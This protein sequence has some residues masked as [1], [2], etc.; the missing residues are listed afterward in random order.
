MLRNKKIVVIL[1]PTA[2]GK[3]KLSIELAKLFNGEIVSADSR[4][5]YKKMDIGTDKISKKERKG[6]PHYL[7]DVASPKKTFTVARYKDLAVKA[8]KKIQKN[9]KI[10]FLVGGTG[11]YIQAV[12]D[13]LLVPEVK[14]DW[15]LRKEL[16]KKSAEELFDILKE[17]DPQRAKSIDR[18][19]KRRLI[20]AIEII[21]KTKKPVS[22]LKKIKPDFEVLKIGIKKSQKSLKKAIKERF[23]RWL[24]QGLIKEVK[25][26]R[27]AGLSWKKIEEFGIHYRQIALYLQNKI[28]REEMIEKSLK[29]L[30]QYAK[31]Q[32]T[33]FKKDKEIH[34][35]KNKGEA[36]KAVKKFLEKN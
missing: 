20:R 32:M 21:T 35:I 22:P 30:E 8:I 6:I 28:S 7:I 24:K 5:V 9:R 34:W 29:E 31:R 18:F 23:S 1:G 36:K 12:T 33:W 17:K 13:G 15:K 4:Q 10:P 19:N 27:K 26:L 11:F 16:E 25:D 14:P 2:S 3:T